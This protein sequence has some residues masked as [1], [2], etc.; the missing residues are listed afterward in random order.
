[1]ILGCLASCEFPFGSEEKKDPE[2]VHVDYVE[3]T[4]LNESSGRLWQEVTVR[5][6]I[7]GD[8]THFYVPETV[9]ASGIFKARYLGVDTPESTGVIEEWGKAASAFTE[10]KLSTAKS[11]IIES[12]SAQ[13]NFDGNG[14]ALLWI[15]YQPE[16]GADYRNLNLELAQVG[17]GNAS[18]E[19]DSAYAS[20][21]WAAYEQAIVEQ[22]Y[23]HSS[24]IDPD[25]PY[26]EAVAV[27]IKELRLNTNAYLGKNV[28]IE[29]VS[30]FNADSTSYIEQ[31]DEE[32]ER[33]W[34]IQV[35][36]GY[37]ST[38]VNLFKQGNLLRVV[39]T[40]SE[41]HGTL[42]ISNIK[43][44]IMRPKDP[45]NSTIIEKNA[46]VAY[47]DTSIAD[48]HSNVTIDGE[49]YSFQEISV[50]NSVSMSGLEVYKTYTTK[51]EESDNYGA[52]T[53]YC[54]KDGKE[55]QVRTA[56]LKD[57]DGTVPAEYISS[58]GIVLA[59]YF[60]GKTINIKGIVE[61]YDS[62]AEGPGVYQI[63]VLNLSGITF[64]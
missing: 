8:T 4:K 50:A 33:Y 13:W 16:E 11:I 1:M 15:W 36:Y 34:A 54:R 26:D 61:Y 37:T 28:V 38:L 62:E 20:T 17:L 3:Q 23:V 5:Y 58:E 35:F 2:H 29:G 47:T 40:L 60:E 41:F 39:G 19:F 45:A 31:Y 9:S 57:K 53:L 27:D 42:Q 44:E 49:T 59:K 7:D 51:N 56:V 63:K 10:E 55:V 12:D 30:S 25:F 32:T 14:R 18:N 43:Y 52:I 21:V 48:W 64:E 22:L 46:A 24:N 6:Y